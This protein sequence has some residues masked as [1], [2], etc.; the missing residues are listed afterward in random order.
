LGQ[1]LSVSFRRAQALVVRRI[2]R[3][4]S[5]AS[6]MLRD[7]AKEIV[8]RLFKP[9]RPGSMSEAQR[10]D[11]LAACDGKITWRMYFAKWGCNRLTL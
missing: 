5:A 3:V 9:S 1:S 8:Q 11:Y 4:A 7:A 2:H 10:I 6:K